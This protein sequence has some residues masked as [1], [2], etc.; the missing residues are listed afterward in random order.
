[1]AIYL[2]GN[3]GRI[4]LTPGDFAQCDYTYDYYYHVDTD[5]GHVDGNLTTSNHVA[6]AC[7]PAGYKATHVYVYSETT[8][9]NGVDVYEANIANDTSTSKLAAGSTNSLLDIT[10]VDASD[11]NYLVVRVSFNANDVYGGYVTIAPI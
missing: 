10:D 6:F 5:G 1:M 4:V 8:D 2:V 7:I 11:T 3:P 9:A